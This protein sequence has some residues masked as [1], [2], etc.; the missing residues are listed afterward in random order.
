MFK[1]NE[2]VRQPNGRFETKSCKSVFQCRCLR[3]INRCLRLITV[4]QLTSILPCEEQY[5]VRGNFL[6]FPPPASQFPRWRNESI[7]LPSS[8]DFHLLP[9]SS[10]LSRFPLWRTNSSL[11]L[12]L[13]PSLCTTGFISKIALCLLLSISSVSRSRQKDQLALLEI[14]HDLTAIVQQGKRSFPMLQQTASIHSSDS[15]PAFSHIPNHALQ[16]PL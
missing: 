8:S 7:S 14:T 9:S 1:V 13:N 2:F 15:C 10:E 4:W 11:Y 5:F 16:N 6:S 3:L 12:V